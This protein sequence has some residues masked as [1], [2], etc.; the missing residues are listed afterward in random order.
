ME[1]VEDSRGH[2]GQGVERKMTVW[3]EEEGRREMRNTYTKFITPLHILL[4]WYSV[5][6]NDCLKL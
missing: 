3:R 4:L 2:Q 1:V 5:S 6:D